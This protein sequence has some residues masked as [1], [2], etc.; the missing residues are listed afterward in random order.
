[1]G[2]SQI[3]CRILKGSELCNPEVTDKN[4]CLEVFR[5]WNT[6]WNEAF[7]EL[8]GDYR[9][10][11]DNV[12]RQDYILTLFLG[13]KCIAMNCFRLAFQ[14][15]QATFSDSYFKN[16]NEQ[17][18]ADLV[19]EGPRILVSSQFSIEEGFRGKS[20]GFN[21]KDVLGVL[22]VELF[23]STDCDVMTGALR[24]NRGVDKVGD[25]I[26]GTK[27]QE[28]TPSGHGDFVDLFAFYRSNLEAARNS[29]MVPALQ[30]LWANRNDSTSLN[31]LGR[32]RAPSRLTQDSGPEA[33]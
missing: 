2:L 24:K 5:H 10:F 23:L 33:A 22:S 4:I 16:W 14:G 30:L 31:Q 32:S 26:S 15:M 29:L 27:I 9:L 11:S 1:M 6:T 7:K 3:T 12:T 25:R 20:L 17:A 28:A 18:C 21:L 8:H 19:K 13:E